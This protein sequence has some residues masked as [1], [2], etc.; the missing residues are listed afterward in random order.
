MTLDE[1]IAQLEKI[2]SRNG[3]TMQVMLVDQSVRVLEAK[4]G[5]DHVLKRDVTLIEVRYE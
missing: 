3:G 2:R 5:C 1:L 4:L